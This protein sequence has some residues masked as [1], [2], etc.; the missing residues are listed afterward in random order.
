MPQ[1]WLRNWFLF[2]GCG[3]GCGQFLDYFK[4]ETYELTQSCSASAPVIAP[5]DPMHEFPS[6]VLACFPIIACSTRSF[7]RSAKKRFLCS[8]T[9]GATIHPSEPRSPFSEISPV[10]FFLQICLPDSSEQSRLPHLAPSLRGVE[11][12]QPEMISRGNR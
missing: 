7:T 11:R 12:T 4:L 10:K 8:L 2:Y 1:I 5:Y 3:C 9:T 6:Q